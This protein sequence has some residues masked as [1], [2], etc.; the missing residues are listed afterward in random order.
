LLDAYSIRHSLQG[1]LQDFVRDS[2]FSDIHLEDLV[3]ELVGL[4]A[5]YR[6][7]DLPLFPEVF[8]F[9]SED[10]LKALAPSSKRTR[11]GGAE[12]RGESAEVVVKNCAPLTGRGWAIFIVKEETRIGYGV[13]RSVLH[14]FATGA[15][16]AMPGLGKDAPVLLIRNLGHLTV[17]L[18]STTGRQFTASLKTL[19]PEPSRLQTHVDEFVDRASSSVVDQES[20]KPY[21]SRLL[22]EAVQHCHGTLLAVIDRPAGADQ[23]SSL[24]DGVW[25]DPPISLAASHANALQTK[26]AEALATLQSDEDLLKGMMGSDGVVVFGSDGS[27]LAYRVFLIP[28]GEEAGKLPVR[29]GGRRR[30]Y[31]LMKLRTPS[32][33]KAALIRS[34]DG[35]TEFSR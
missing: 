27:I 1:A 8:I 21:L 14:S 6:E 29:G 18:R 9:H 23:P 30:A 11:L 32:I 22:T 34:Q 26:T 25:P 24:G 12:L 17:E 2:G 3:R 13:F 10:G 16:E 20:F 28:D 15:T 4:L 5:S 31:E 35:E 7:E 19:Q 33:F